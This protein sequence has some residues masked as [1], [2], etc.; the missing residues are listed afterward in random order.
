MAEKH[1]MTLDEAELRSRL[2]R[3][4]IIV[5]SGVSLDWQSIERQVESL[6]FGEYY[7]V[8]LRRGPRGSSV[9]LTPARNQAGRP[10]PR[11]SI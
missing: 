10:G 7:V 5:L 8:A 4:E 9:C 6:G 1:P 2:E 3:R 11:V